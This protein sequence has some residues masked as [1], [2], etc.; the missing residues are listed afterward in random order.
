MYLSRAVL[1]GRSAVHASPMLTHGFVVARGAVAPATCALVRS[2]ALAESQS[3][4]HW[5]TLRHAYQ[6]LAGGGLREQRHRV[7][8]PLPLSAPVDALVRAALSPSTGL[9][10]AMRCVGLSADAALVELSVMLAL[11]GATAQR[12]HTDVPPDH[13][14]PMAT[15]WC[16]LQ[17]TPEEM[18]AT[19]V[20]P[21]SPAAVATAADWARQRSLSAAAAARQFEPAAAG[22]G[23]LGGFSWAHA[24][25]APCDAPFT[26][27]EL[28]VGAATALELATGDSF[29]M[30]CRVFHFGGG[31]GTQRVR[32]Q[33]SATFQEP[34]SRDEGERRTDG[35][36]DGFTYELHRSLRGHGVRLGRFV[37]V[38]RG[39]DFV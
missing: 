36:S 7:H 2:H 30:D 38:E 29:V 37:D 11:P 39:R 15:L 32:A 13:T 28:G 8:L 12:A 9:V 17:D 20:C 22:E 26:P 14:Q 19:R 6:R 4:W 33:L 16:A 3:P 10:D 34:A 23:L 31:N 5:P 25:A 1:A 24:A 35:G 27:E 21:A 18:G